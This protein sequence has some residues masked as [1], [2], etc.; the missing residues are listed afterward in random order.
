ME[1]LSKIGIDL[2]GMLLYLVNYGLLL[3]VL[4]Y[5]FYPKVIKNLEKRR[6]TIKKN[7]E[8]TAHL[9]KVLEMQIEQHKK[10]KEELRIQMAADAATLKKEMQEKR[11]EMIQEMESERQKM[12]EETTAQLDKKRPKS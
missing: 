7:I 4:G 12:I 3:G 10:E 5:F 8:D 9:Q 1:N 11:S 2:W 6:A